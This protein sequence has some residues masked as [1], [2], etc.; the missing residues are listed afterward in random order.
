MNPAG[1]GNGL[2]PAMAA[3]LVRCQAELQA[4]ARE[5]IAEL[6]L[7]TMLG[8]LGTTQQVG[9]SVSG[10]MVWRDLDF[11]VVAPGLS[12]TRAFETLWPLVTHPRIVELHYR[13]E[14]GPRSPSG[15]SED[16]RFYFVIH[17][18]TPAGNVWKIDL[19][20][21]LADGPRNLLA[22]AEELARRLT[23]ETRLAILWIKDVWHRLPV[24]PYEVG[25]TDVYQAVLEYGVRTPTEFEA[26]L[27]QR[28]LQAG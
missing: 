15:R 21:W 14:Q 3:E 10:L 19:S 7:L 2:T 11:I 27:R 20:L 28:G 25:G 24:Y 16:D 4:E 8:R 26:Y 9:S 22:P 13:N 12:I 6:D 17:Y 23:A 1:S 18:Q 5:V